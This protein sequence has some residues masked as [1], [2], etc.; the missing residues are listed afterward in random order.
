M[1]EASPPISICVGTTVGWPGI[2]PCIR[3]FLHEA[4]AV[5]AEVIVADGSGLPPPDDPDVAASVTWRRHDENSVFKLVARNVSEARGE[6]VALTEDHCTAR[7]GWVRA[8]LR[9][10]AEYPSA[11]AVG[12]AIENAPSGSSALRWASHLMTQGSH[13]APLANG[14]SSRI[15]NEA[16]ISYKRWA[17]RG[18]DDHPLG[19]M[20]IHQTRALAD[21]GELLVNDDRIVVDHHESLGVRATAVIHFDDGRTISGFRRRRMGHGD[22]LRLIASPLLPLYR[23]SRVVRNAVVKGHGRTVLTAL[24]WL[25]ALEYC[26]GVGELM[27]YLRGAGRSP[28]GLR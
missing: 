21:R 19:F 5:G 9:A 17:L 26:H 22:W 10:H 4:R 8:I 16:N 11:A 12:G 25:V 7:P 23:T 13:M 15:A 28:Y 18:V 14:P 20:T 3:S 6:I 27:G 24:P 1:S 2:E